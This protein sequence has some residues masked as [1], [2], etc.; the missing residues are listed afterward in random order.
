MGMNAAAPQGSSP[1]AAGAARILVVDDNEMNRDLLTR[2]LSRQGYRTDT[3]EN[4]AQALDKLAREPYDLVLL[5]IT[6][7]EMDGYQV[8]ARMREDAAIPR[9]PVV[10]VSAIDEADSVVRCLELG[11]E[12]YLSKP[13]NPLIL[14]ARVEASLA[15]KLLQ[16]KADEHARVLERE[17]QI[18]RDIQTGFLPDHLPQ[19]HGWSLDARFIP[20]HQVAGDFYDAFELA[21]GRVALVV[22]DVCD[23]GVGAALYMALFRS[24]IRAIAPQGG[25]GEAAPQ[26][27]A[28]TLGFVNDYIA[29]VH[30]RAS[31]FATVFFALLD[32]ASGRL[33]YANAGH[34]APM[35]QRRGAG[36]PERLLPTGLALGLLPDRVCAVREL[37]LGPGDALLA[38]TD[39]AIEGQPSDAEA[40]LAEL[41]T[42][43]EG[44]AC[45]LLD[46]VLAGLTARTGDAGAA[47]DDHAASQ[48]QHDDVTLLA[49]V[50]GGD[51]VPR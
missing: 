23:K 39:G 29:T 38:Y 2:R 46:Q 49:L 11:A 32:P 25:A 40:L 7:P 34:D 24:L 5:D 16:D 17:L 31:M 26:T 21:G 44:N 35:L 22:A 48:G 15:R 47:G 43:H 1:G 9:V 28:R 50:R 14:K 6:M 45:Q 8:L 3:A 4:G 37:D 51:A 36:A 10:M 33:S 41:I 27:L 13:F 18:G 42:R 19:P 20:A 12:D 30:E